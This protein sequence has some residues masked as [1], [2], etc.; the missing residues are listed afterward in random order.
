MSVETDPTRDATSQ[1]VFICYRRQETAPYAGR[2]YDAMV[3]KFGVENV[4]MDLDLDPGVDFVDRITKVVSGCVAL[5]VVIG[6]RWAELENEDGTRRIADPEDFVRLE[7]E[8]G[9]KRNDVTP[10]PVLV[11]GAEMPHREDLPPELR[12]ITRRNALELSEG[13]WRYDIGRLLGILDELLPDQP[14]PVPPTPA[15]AV[16]W[17]LAPEGMLVAAVAAYLARI[18]GIPSV[19]EVE[20]LGAIV[21]RRGISFGLAGAA[22][23]VWIA[24]R[25]WHAFP[26]RY[27]LRALLIGA[28]AGALGGAIFGVFVYGG[29]NRSLDERDL[30]DLLACTVTGGIFGGLIGGLWK[31][32]RIEAA[33]VAGAFGG[34]LAQAVVVLTNWQNTAA[35]PSAARLGFSAAAITGAALTALIAGSRAEARNQAAAGSPRTGASHSA[36]RTGGILPG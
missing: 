26:L 19:F 28:F 15:V 11:G 9:L 27:L 29:E 30:I 17:R 5:I 35:G 7:V 16:P 6:P 20:K 34:L 8:T 4:F 21:A 22:L 31:P 10:I 13:R 36:G 2:I 1:K 23:A 25:V 24:V 32:R 33:I 14:G 18:G 3:A 12:P